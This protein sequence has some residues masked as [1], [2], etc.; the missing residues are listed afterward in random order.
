MINA[1]RKALELDPA[2]A[3]AQT[4]ARR[5]CM[6]TSGSGPNAK[7][8]YKRAL[9][10]EPERP[11]L[12]TSAFRTGCLSQGR[13]EEAIAWAQRASE[14]DPLAGLGSNVGWILFQA[15]HYDEAI[16]ELRRVLAVS[17][18]DA[19]ALLVPGFALIATGQPDQAIAPLEKARSLSERSSAVIGVLV[20]AYAHAGRRGDA[21]RLLEE[22]KRRKKTSY[23]PPAAFVNAYLGLG[24]NEQAF[25]WLERAYQEQSYILL[26]GTS[27][28]RSLA[29]RSS[30]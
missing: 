5:T 16:R 9:G 8:E 28:F 15:R 2:T 13:T 22:L 3:E 29:R 14:L 17:P 7:A 1:L 23:V 25:A 24:D 18:E 26:Q 4:Y 30:F 6:G 11:W 12:R 20:R 27:L 19:Y 21:L 10:I